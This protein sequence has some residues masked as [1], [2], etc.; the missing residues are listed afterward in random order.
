[1]RALIIGYGR[2]GR[3]HAKALADLG[4][5]VITADPDPAA[6]ADFRRAPVLSFRRGTEIQVVAVAAPIPYLAETAAQWAGFPGHLLVE[7]PFAANLHQAR[8]LADTL[9]GQRVAVGYVERFNPQVRALR[10]LIAGRTVKA[11]FTRWNDRP[12]PDPSLD[13]R[14]HDVD[15]AHYLEIREYHCS[16]LAPAPER[17]REIEVAAPGWTE[18]VDLTAHTTSPLHALWHAFL[19][20]RPG[21]ATTADAVAV[22]LELDRERVAA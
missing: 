7:K 1:M 19:S 6:R 11:R 22:H 14:S 10:E 2:M 9:E 16:T 3:F 15:L 13:L 17:R 4:Y 20:D 12:S 8:E 18:T 21:H 5:D